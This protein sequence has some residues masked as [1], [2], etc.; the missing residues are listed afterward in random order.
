M[1]YVPLAFS[2]T[3]ARGQVPFALAADL[4]EVW[5][6]EFGGR[7]AQRFGVTNIRAMTPGTSSA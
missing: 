1:R 3:W 7:R 4:A 5:A 2:Y 6:V